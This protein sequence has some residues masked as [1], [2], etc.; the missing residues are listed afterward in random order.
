[1]TKERSM[2]NIPKRIAAALAATA[3]LAVAVPAAASAATPT[4]SSTGSSSICF[5]GIPDL[6]PFGPLGPYGPKGPYG[7][8]GPLH[9]QTNPIGNAATCGGLLTYILR[10][11]T[12]DSFVHASLLPGQGR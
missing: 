12:L 3:A 8:N 5:S 11:G 10:G 7:P 1:M 9:D 2:I 6:G 4:L